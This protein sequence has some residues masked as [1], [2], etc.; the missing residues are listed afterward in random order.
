MPLNSRIHT[1]QEF[2]VGTY[3]IIIASDENEI[4]ERDDAPKQEEEAESSQSVENP[5]KSGSS[6]DVDVVV[7]P[8]KKQKSARQDKEYSVARGQD[9]VEVACVINFDLPTSAK[10]YT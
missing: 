5:G 2:N 9:F 6:K 7:P 10:S 1:I 8:K 3:D 4:M